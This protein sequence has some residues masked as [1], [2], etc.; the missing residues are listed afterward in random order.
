[1][2][3]FL[4]NVRGTRLISNRTATTLQAEW[5]PEMNSV[6]VKVLVRCCSCLGY[7]GAVAVVVVVVV[8]AV[9]ADVATVDA[10]TPSNR[11]ERSTNLH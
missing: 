1:M 7:A 2:K 10:R 8:V 6:P 11:T 9:A 4:E 3:T 5:K